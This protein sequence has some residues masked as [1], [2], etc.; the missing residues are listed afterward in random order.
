MKAMNTHCTPTS[1]GRA[2][3]AALLLAATGAVSAAGDHAQ[4]HDES[5]SAAHD[6][7]QAGGEH[8][9][10]DG[11]GDD[12]HGHEAGGHGTRF[13]EP[14]A[15]QAADRTIRVTAHD[16]MRFEPRRIRVKA[17]ETIRFVVVNIG[18]LRHSFTLGTPRGQEAHE[19]EMQGMAT[20]RLASHMR[21]DPT[22]MVI[23]PGGRDTLTWRFA[24]GGPVEFACHIPGH[25]AAGMI[26]R[27]RID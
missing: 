2:L 27:I 19:R 13:G 5:G 15:A 26:G 12:G 11:H 21:G 7:Q 16:K 17:G 25:F 9:H 22:G 6:T 20:D 8:G 14:A 4:G 18:K 3:A 10:G 1:L 24:D 23:P